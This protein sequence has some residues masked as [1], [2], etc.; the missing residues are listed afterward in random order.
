MLFVKRILLEI[1]KGGIKTFIKKFITV[2]FLIL[3]IPIYLISFISLIVIYII[4]PSY[5]IRFGNL[6]SSRL[7]HFVANTELYLCE[8]EK[9]I[10]LPK[11]RFIDLFFFQKISNYQIAKMWKRE[12]HVLPKFLLEP[13]FI[14]NKYNSN[15]FS[16]AKKHLIKSSCS[17]RDVY[18]LLDKTEPHLHFTKEEIIEGEKYLK[19]FG[20]GTNSKFVCLIVRDRAYLEHTSPLNNWSYHNFRNSDIDN[21]LLAAEYLTERGYYVFRMGSIVEKKINSKNE[22][23]IDYANSDLRSD[24]LDVFLGANCNFC[25]STSC[26][27]DSIPYTFRVPIAYITVPIGLFSTFSSKFLIMTKHYYSKNLKRNLKFSEIIN[28]KFGKFKT[29]KEFENADIDLKENSPKEIKEFIVEMVD[30]YE[31]KWK[32][33]DNSK[34]IQ[35]KFWDNYKTFIKKENLEDLH[36]KLSAKFSVN[37]LEKNKEWLN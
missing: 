14:I 13:I 12:L 23:I 24:F 5:L 36:G 22:K 25:I 6:N 10:N 27:F 4:G 20:L 29:T 15:Y 30:R 16:F 8:K 21:F 28:K 3:S 33:D 11:Q 32:D 31:N 1:K 35:S 17:D 19:K 7:G 26:G 37:F 2:F 18:N 9:K 34:L